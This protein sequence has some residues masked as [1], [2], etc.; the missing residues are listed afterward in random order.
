MVDPS[1]LAAAT[2]GVVSLVAFVISGASWRAMVKTGNR[3]I[4]YV[5]A[6]FLVVALKNAVKA[7]HLTYEAETLGWE[8]AFSLLDLLAVLLIVFPLVPLRRRAPQ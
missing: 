5:A 6:G 1:R 7:W 8:V 2:T 3:N 4:S